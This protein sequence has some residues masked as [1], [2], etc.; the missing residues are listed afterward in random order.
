M[1][2][3]VWTNLIASFIFLEGSIVWPSKPKI[4]MRRYF[5]PGFYWGIYGEE[6]ICHSIRDSGM[7]IYRYGHLL[8]HV[9]KPYLRINF[10]GSALLVV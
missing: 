4:N 10:F 9:T 5:V 2:I 8:L 1:L 3:S 7:P 6:K